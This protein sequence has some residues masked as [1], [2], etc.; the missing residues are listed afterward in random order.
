MLPGPCDNPLSSNTVFTVRRLKEPDIAALDAILRDHVRDLHS[1]AIVDSEIQAIHGYMQGMPD[2]TGRGRRYQVVSDDEGRVLG[3]M[4]LARPESRMA[5]H[6]GAA[7]A[8]T[9]VELLNA[10]VASSHLHGKGVGRLLFSRLCEM[11]ATEGAAYLLVNSGPRY[12][13]SWGFYDR[14]CDSSHGFIDDY[15]GAGRHAKTWM[16]ALPPG[17]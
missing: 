6:F 11:G 17:A 12:R 3:C 16:K 8:G 1:G 5:Q 4:A 13:R 14:V 2:E 10:F 9:A 7:V 15:Y